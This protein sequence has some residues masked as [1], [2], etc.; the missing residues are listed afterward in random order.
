MQGVQNSKKLA[1]H[2][3]TILLS[4]TVD[5]FKEKLERAMSQSRAMREQL[6]LDT[7]LIESIKMKDS[8][9]VQVMLEKQGE[10]KGTT[11]VQVVYHFQNWDEPRITSKCDYNYI[12]TTLETGS[13]KGILA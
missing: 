3:R 9:K 8:T 13:P 1:P 7:L 5:E 10:K 4:E 11:S 12:C 2:L 6:T